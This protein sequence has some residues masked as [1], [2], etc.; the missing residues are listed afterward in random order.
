MDGALVTQMALTHNGALASAHFPGSP[1]GK[2][3]P[4]G[5]ADL[6]IVDYMPPTPLTSGN[7]P[8]HVIFG[9]Q[10]GMVTTTIAGGMILMKDRKL[11]TLDEERISRR[12]RELAP[13]VWKRFEENSR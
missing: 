8:W 2:V 12:A 11:T 3:V 10:P 4:G 6:A 7:F 9:M 1:V 5:A 13:R